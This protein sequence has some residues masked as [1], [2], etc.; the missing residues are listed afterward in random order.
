MSSDDPANK[1]GAALTGANPIPSAF[2]I[3]TTL[4]AV[5]PKLNVNFGAQSEHTW[6][7]ISEMFKRS[8]NCCEDRIIAVIGVPSLL[9]DGRLGLDTLHDA[10]R[11]ELFQNAK[12]D[13]PVNNNRTTSTSGG[14][15]SATANTAVQQVPAVSRSS[16]S[17]AETAIELQDV[18][19]A[20]NKLEDESLI[21]AEE[22]GS[23]TMRDRFRELFSRERPKEPKVACDGGCVEV[24]WTSI[25]EKTNRDPMTGYGFG[26]I[27]V[28]DG[29]HSNTAKIHCRL[30]MDRRVCKDSVTQFCGKTVKPWLENKKWWEVKEMVENALAQMVADIEAVMIRGVTPSGDA[31]QAEQESNIDE[32]KWDIQSVQTVLEEYRKDDL[33]QRQYRWIRTRWP[34]MFRKLGVTLKVREFTTDLREGQTAAS[35]EVQCELIWYAVSKRYYVQ[36]VQDT[37]DGK[38]VLLCGKDRIACHSV[39][40]NFLHSNAAT[41]TEYGQL[42][43]DEGPGYHGDRVLRSIKDIEKERQKAKTGYYVELVGC[44]ALTYATSTSIMLLAYVTRHTLGSISANRNGTGKDPALFL[45][46]S[47]LAIFSDVRDAWLLTITPMEPKS[48]R[49]RLA[50]FALLALVLCII[51][52]TFQLIFHEQAPWLAPG[53][54][55]ITSAGLLKQNGRKPLAAIASAFV[56]AINYFTFSRRRPAVWLLNALSVIVAALWL[57]EA[58]VEAVPWKAGN[59]FSDL[60]LIEMSLWCEVLLQGNHPDSLLHPDHAVLAASLAHMVLYGQWA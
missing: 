52:R 43:L 33:H 25:S 41:T 30:C 49:K 27:E 58:F 28:G 20:R 2:P 57:T 31:D 1:L 5:I 40:G 10:V 59:G 14:L 34:K 47:E 45:S 19:G 17:T 35:E 15:A 26:A 50:W 12:P 53:L 38:T 3:A 60:V 36:R 7:E 37:F 29:S 11:L 56:L 18:Q 42:P 51:L 55:N 54:G 22:G 9:R 24:E 46:A 6:A 23:R 44:L 13:R 16:T 48:R 32:F 39:V 8:V 4:L 21:S